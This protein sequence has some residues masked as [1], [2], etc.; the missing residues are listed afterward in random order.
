[1]HRKFGALHKLILL[2]RL[3]CLDFIWSVDK[4]DR[5]SIDL[6]LIKLLKV[7]QVI[8]PQ[9]KILQRDDLKILKNHLQSTIVLLLNHLMYQQLD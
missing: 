8:K 9:R 5:T 7:T 2:K 3:N 4:I 6:L 1:M